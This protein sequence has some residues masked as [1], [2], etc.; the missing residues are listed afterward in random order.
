[1]S[2]WCLNCYRLGTL[3]QETHFPLRVNSG[4]ADKHFIK[5]SQRRQM[6][7]RKEN[8]ARVVSLLLLFSLSILSQRS[9]CL[10]MFSLWAAA[11]RWW[12]HAAFILCVTHICVSPRGSSSKEPGLKRQPGQA[13]YGGVSPALE[14]SSQRP[15]F[16]Q[17]LPVF[18]R[19]SA[20][21]HLILCHSHFVSRN[22]FE[23]CETRTR[24]LE[25]TSFI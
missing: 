23:H 11:P 5:T 12:P 20:H 8:L 7:K 6:N 17:L 13:Q 3:H 21:I 19:S 25:F 1:M 14:K 4:R 16:F 15:D 9:H 24:F 22:F 10:S 18:P 2:L